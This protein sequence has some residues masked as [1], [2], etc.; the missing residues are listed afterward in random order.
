MNDLVRNMV[1]VA[2]ETSIYNNWTWNKSEIPSNMEQKDFI[3]ELYMHDE[4]LDVEE[5]NGEISVIF[6]FHPEHEE[7]CCL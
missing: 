1:D 2:R 4:V 7:I 3:E 5:Y 6:C